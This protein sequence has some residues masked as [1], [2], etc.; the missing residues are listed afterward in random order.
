MVNRNLIKNIDWVILI[1]AFFICLLGVMT[2]YSATA[3]QINN[4]YGRFY[5]KQLYWIGCGFVVMLFTMFID[6]HAIGKS[7]YF[8]Y[9]LNIL[10]I[11]AVYFSHKKIAH[12]GRWI[13]IG[14]ISIQP[15]EFMKFILILTVAK[16]LHEKRKNVLG[17][18]DML[19]PAVIL[20]VPLVLIIK[21][22]DLG[23]AMLLVPVFLCIIYL[24]GLR[25]RVLTALLVTGLILTIPMWFMLKPY[26][27][28]RISSF[29]DP[30]SDPMGS[31]YHLIQSK[32]AVG[33]GGLIGRGYLK[34]T[35]SK[36]NFVPAQ[37][38]DFIFSV[39][40]EEWGFSG[41]VVL[42]LLF[43]LFLYRGL[44]IAVS[45]RDKLGLL[46]AA[47][48][49]CMF[50]FHIFVN[51]GMVIGMMPIT[52]FPLCFFSYG[53]SAMITNFAC[54]GILLNVKMRRFNNT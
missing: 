37:H 13:K 39:F 46:M 16:Y 50:G 28:A 1:L 8:L 17:F 41:S 42:L 15:S 29:I 51:I 10:G 14:G 6:Y 30:S 12:V 7:S 27:K 25:A 2:V 31:G 23:T 9:F 47:G 22:P 49:V 18:V 20:I 34:G 43:L 40:A 36:L 26:Q 11:V 45:A 19:P 48:I 21:Q 24:A 53:G 4:P 54:L 52:G 3:K 38:T 33:S 44:E 5:V 32:I 35:Q